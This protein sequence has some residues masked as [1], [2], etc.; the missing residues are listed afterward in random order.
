MKR[1]FL[2]KTGENTTVA[3][4]FLNDSLVVLLK[5]ELMCY[6]RLDA[7]MDKDCIKYGVPFIYHTDKILNYNTVA[8]TMLDTDLRSQHQKIFSFSKETILIIF[9]DMVI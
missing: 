4:K 1:I 3:I 2:G 8:M 6:E 5:R 9:R 7:M